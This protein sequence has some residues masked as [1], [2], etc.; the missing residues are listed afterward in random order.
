MNNEEI[1]KIIESIIAH[2]N[3]DD[4]Y[5]YWFDMK[6]AVKAV[7]NPEFNKAGKVHDWRNHAPDFAEAL[8][9]DLPV[10]ARFSIWFMA[11]S[12]ASSEHWD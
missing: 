6:S 12:N 2:E 8:W 1:T 5:Y 3:I 9:L 7:S 4:A 11:E 10:E